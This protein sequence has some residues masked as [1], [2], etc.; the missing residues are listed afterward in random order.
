MNKYKSQMSEKILNL[1]LE[2]IW[3]LTGEEYITVKKSGEHV[4]HSRS[5]VPPSSAL[6]HERSNDKKILELTNQIVHLL[7]EE[8]AIRCDDLT[9]YF[10][11]DEWAYLEGHKQLYKDLLME[12]QD[13]MSSTASLLIFE[14]MK[15]LYQR[16]R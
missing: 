16:G 12:D 2:I 15:E 5:I 14:K 1:T 7:T 13:S 3:L 8:V 10:T 11:M 4:A 9:V 6:I